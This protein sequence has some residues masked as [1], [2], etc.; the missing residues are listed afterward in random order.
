[1]TAYL[2]HALANP[3]PKAASCSKRGDRHIV[4]DMTGGQLALK[5]S[6]KAVHL[7]GIRPKPALG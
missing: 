7:I 3:G 6:V 4:E 2:Q 5:L 1:M